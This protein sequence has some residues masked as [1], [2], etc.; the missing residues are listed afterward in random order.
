MPE[1][2]FKV[3]RANALAI[4]GKAAVSLAL[5]IS[6]GEQEQVHSIALT[7]QLQIEPA[8]RRYSDAEKRALTDLFGEPA[9]WGTTV[10]PLFWTTINAAVPG[11]AGTT[12]FDL[13]IPYDFAS[14]IAAAKYFRAIEQG[15]VPITLLFSGRL[16]YL[17]AG[18]LLMAPISWS[19][20]ATCR[21]PEQ[22]WK[23]AI[24]ASHAERVGV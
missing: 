7:V 16:H 13:R 15:D 4:C 8:R 5:R 12:C 14:D 1:L 9:R 3:E 23:Q 2:Q 17:S 10:R 22:V 6:N 19:Q 24:V 21:I 20:E 11:F 18:S